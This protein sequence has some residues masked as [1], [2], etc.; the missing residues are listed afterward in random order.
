MVDRAC[1]DIERE[2]R[3]LAPEGGKI[4]ESVLARATI[5]VNTILRHKEGISAYKLHTARSQDTGENLQLKDKDI[6]NNQ[7][8]LRKS[9]EE[10]S[11]PPDIAVGDTVTTI[12]SQD[13]HKAREIY[14]VTGKGEGKVITQRLLHPL[15]ETPMKFMS[16]KYEINP[17]HLHRINRPPSSVSDYYNTE[18][19]NT[20]ASDTHLQHKSVCAPWS[21]VNPKY[22]EDS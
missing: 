16:R 17:K 21:P 12:S 14:L 20:V 15:S 6:C 1:Q 2:L 5:A 7:R 10:K 11:S 19:I 18:D 9:K 13:K 8:K 4:S 22:Y 3:K